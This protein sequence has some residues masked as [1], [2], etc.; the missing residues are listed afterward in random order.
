MSKTPSLDKAFSQW[1]RQF[2]ADAGQSARGI[3]KPILVVCA[4]GGGIALKGRLI[5]GSWQFIRE[6]G[7]QTPEMIDEQA[8]HHTSPAAA[9]WRGALRLMDRYPWHCFVAT[10]V[11][12]EFA[13]RVWQAYERRW[14]RGERQC[15]RYRD[16]WE[17]ACGRRGEEGDI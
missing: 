14:R 1:Q 8:I 13:E 11:H 7:D 10:E 6:L 3:F 2:I 12:Q 5:G 4:E 9:S 17:V 16:R 15:E